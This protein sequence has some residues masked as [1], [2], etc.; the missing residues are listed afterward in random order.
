MYNKQFF[1]VNVIVSKNND[2]SHEDNTASL[3]K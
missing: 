1:I 3:K 2:Y